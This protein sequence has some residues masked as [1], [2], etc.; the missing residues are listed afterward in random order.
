[1][2]KKRWI[3]VALA[4]ISTASW[5]SN[6]FEIEGSPRERDVESLE[7]AWVEVS[8]S[9]GPLWIA[10]VVDA[11]PRNGTDSRCR[12]ELGEG[13]MHWRGGSGVVTDNS[14]AMIFLELRDGRL[15]DITV[16]RGDCQIDARGVDL[17]LWRGASTAATFE[18]LERIALG[19]SDAELREEGL[20]AVAILRLSQVDALLERLATDDRSEDVRHAALFWLGEAR[21]TAGFLALR[22]LEERVPEEDLEEALVFA[23][24]VNEDPR[25]VQRLLELARGHQSAAIRGSALFWVAQEAGEVATATLERAVVEDPDREVREQAVFGLS[26]LPA[27]RGVPALIKVARTHR[28]PEVREAAFFWLGQSNDPRAL[29]LFAEVLGVR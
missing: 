11:T 20:A 12:L 29:D 7:T 1:M 10:W 21:E 9:R 26:Q 17:E 3:A 6:G 28:D 23:Y 5:A 4:L 16:V 15:R 24:S 18:L 25:S 8:A 19:S 13:Q 14:R 27:E 22:R 2:K